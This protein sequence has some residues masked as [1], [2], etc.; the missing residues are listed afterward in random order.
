M[1]MTNRFKLAGPGSAILLGALAGF[2][3]V[4]ATPLYADQCLPAPKGAAPAGSHWY[5]RA[6][7]A[8]KKNCWY[9]R[10]ASKP[11]ASAKAVAATASPQPET[12]LQ[13]SVANARAEADEASI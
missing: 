11:A 6:D 12:P 8:T 7:R 4:Q 3:G 2:L 1:H 9:V 13:P 5:Y 10:A